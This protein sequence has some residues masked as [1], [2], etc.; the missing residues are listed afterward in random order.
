ME[1]LSSTKEYCSSM[2]GVSLLAD[3][4]INYCVMTRQEGISVFLPPH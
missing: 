3:S 2:V 4:M 1:G